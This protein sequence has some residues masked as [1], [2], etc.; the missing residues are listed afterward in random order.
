[1]LEQF[2]RACA[3]LGKDGHH[4]FAPLLE[5]SVAHGFAPEASTVDVLSTLEGSGKSAKLAKQL[6]ALTE[7]EGAMQAMNTQLLEARIA[8]AERWA[9]A[10]D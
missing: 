1:M 10:A 4:I 5:L 9:A 6:L 2:A 8:R 3:N 7:N